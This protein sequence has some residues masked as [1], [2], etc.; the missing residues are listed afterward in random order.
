M[1]DLEDSRRVKAFRRELVKSIKRFPNDR[2]SLQALEAKS[3]T[4]L[5]IRYIGWR[6]RFVGQRKRRV[7][8]WAA[9]DSDPRSVGLKANIDALA[10]VVEAGGNLDPY[11]SEKAHD[12][13][14]TPAADPKTP[15]PELWKDKDHLLNV[16]GLHH[17]HLGMVEKSPGVMRRT[18][19]VLFASVTRDE[20]EI[21]GLFDHDA[22]EHEDDGSMTPERQKLWGAYLSREA[23]G[24]LPGQL[25]VGG[26]AGGGISLSGEPNA[27]VQAAIRHARI[28]RELDPTLDDPDQIRR[29]FPSIEAPAKPKLR[30]HY[31]HLDFGLISEADG[32][33]GVLEKG[34]N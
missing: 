3:L 25:S 16:M 10:L 26:F 4:E 29:L 33:F 15:N 24:L 23:N 18:N 11:L 12:D 21:I 32:V 20:F 1:A 7:T 19:E 27:V 2:A 6:T 34:P 22:F 28:M 14:Y 13:G 9:L 31:H 5:L 8:G 17:F 30:W